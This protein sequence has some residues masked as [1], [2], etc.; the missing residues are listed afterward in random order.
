MVFNAISPSIYTFNIL[1]DY[2]SC[3]GRVEEGIAYVS[4][5][6]K[7]NIPL[8]VATFTALM[9]GYF[10]IDEVDNV[11]ELL[12]IMDRFGVCLD[13]ETYSTVLTELFHMGMF[14]EAL[15]MWSG[16]KLTH[17]FTD[18]TI[19]NNINRAACT[20]CMCVTQMCVQLYSIKEYPFIEKYRTKISKEK[21]K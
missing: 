17:R 13:A 12:K 5:M 7:Y 18:I 8:S 19:Y 10:K 16:I 21:T 14:K 1:V 15:E 6:F 3:Q 2:Y 4:L 20:M 11:F 9:K